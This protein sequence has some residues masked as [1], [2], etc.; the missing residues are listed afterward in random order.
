[1]DVLG[2]FLNVTEIQTKEKFYYKTGRNEGIGHAVMRSG[3]DLPI[4]YIG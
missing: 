1:L 2:N 4:G 3:S